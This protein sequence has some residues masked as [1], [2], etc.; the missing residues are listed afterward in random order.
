MLHE[1]KLVLD[2]D[3]EELAYLNG[4]EKIVGQ[5]FRVVTEVEDQN[6]IMMKDAEIVSQNDW[7]GDKGQ[8]NNEDKADVYM[9]QAT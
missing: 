7:L 6:S 1:M 2:K 8:E 4:Q 9:S 5:T 3:K